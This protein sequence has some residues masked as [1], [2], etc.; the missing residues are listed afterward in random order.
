MK[1]FVLVLLLLC[2]AVFQITVIKAA[3]PNFENTTAEKHQFTQIDTDN[4][5]YVTFDEFSTWHLHW[6][7][8]RFDRIDANKDGHL[9]EAEYKTLRHSRMK[10]KIESER[11]RNEKPLK[12]PE[13]K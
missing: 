10:E 1:N 3:P 8:W 2:L 5:G 11:I 6:L 13:S 9:S 4:D 12:G 7:Q